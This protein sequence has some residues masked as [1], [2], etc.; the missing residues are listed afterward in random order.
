MMFAVTL[1]L[2]GTLLF[3]IDK[4][5]VLA[6]NQT[7][8]AIQ[9]QHQKL[10]HLM[11]LHMAGQKRSVDLQQVLLHH[12]M[13]EQD[14]VL[15]SFYRDSV[16]YGRH[17]D[18]LAQLISN[19]P[20]EQN[21]LAELDR[22]AHDIG[23]LQ[24]EIAQMAMTGQVEE[25]RNLFLSRGTDGLDTFID[26]VNQFSNYQ[27]S[28]I[29]AVI[30]KARHQI[31]HLMQTVMLL[32][33]ALVTLSMVFSLFLT[34][35]FNK[36]NENLQKANDNLEA[37]EH[38]R[39]QELIEAQRDLLKQNSLLQHLS[40]TDPLTQLNNRL[41]IENILEK[42]HENYLQ[43]SL[44][45][46]V[47]LIDLDHFKQINDTQGH[48]TGDR[49]LQFFADLLRRHFTPSHHLGRWGGEEFIVV[50]EGCD[51]V[52]AQERAPK[53]T[54]RLPTS[55]IVPTWRFMRPNMRDATVLPL[56]DPNF[57][58]GKPNNALKM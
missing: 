33:A 7:T 52:H 1:F 29:Q 2:V 58:A 5:T 11:N 39:T 38:K 26:Q 34:R 28:E 24:D 36:I 49:T 10:H 25:V 20:F 43:K 57:Q 9:I 32:A 21:W 41:E 55:C 19:T 44:P 8:Q 31:D 47:L 54:N 22:G 18:K 45:Y 23:P 3:I 14:R 15:M 53:R 30:S 16:D 51:V 48:M 37:E 35:R 42:Q 13:F 6:L 56:A 4:Q 17:R 12:D 40:S 46:C 50:L 27:I